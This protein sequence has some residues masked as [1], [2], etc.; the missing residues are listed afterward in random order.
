MGAQYL[1]ILPKR[2]INTHAIPSYFYK[3]MLKYFMPK[4]TLLK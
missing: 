2:L 1:F 4:T 3:C